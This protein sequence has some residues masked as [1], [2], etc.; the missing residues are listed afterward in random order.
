[1]E[2]VENRIRELTVNQEEIKNI[3]EKQICEGLSEEQN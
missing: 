2:R 1:M 3:L